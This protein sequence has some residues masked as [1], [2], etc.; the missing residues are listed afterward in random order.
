[1]LKNRFEKFESKRFS[2]VNELR[3][4]LDTTEYEFIN[5]NPAQVELLDNGVI[6]A[7]NVKMP[8]YLEG[9]E[10]FFEKVLKIPD[11]FSTWI[12]YST[13]QNNVHDICR[14][15]LEERLTLCINKEKI[16]NIIN[17]IYHPVPS[18][19]ILHSFEREDLEWKFLEWSHEGF[20]IQSLGNVQLMAEPKIGHVT[21]VGSNFRY[22]PTGFF[23]PQGSTLLFTLV[24]SNGAVLG[25]EYGKLKM[26]LYGDINM[27][28]FSRTLSQKIDNLLINSDKMLVRFNKMGDTILT[29]S[30]AFSLFRSVTKATDQETAMTVFNLEDEQRIELKVKAKEWET[31]EENSEYNF[32]ETYYGI[33]DLANQYNGRTRRRLQV[34]SGKMID[35]EELRN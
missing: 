4:Q 31:K 17:G 33:T 24:C 8:I 1:M 28:T 14:E 32:Y 7:E 16:V 27:E 34:L 35:F 18:K 13:L 23:D 30:S 11:P 10:N 6:Q 19:A 5:V 22:S 12:P 26:K 25:R 21:R 20:N 2:T 29:N 9:A 3:K 15:K